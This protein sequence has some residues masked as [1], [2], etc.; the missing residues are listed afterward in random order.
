[1][2][3]IT[4]TSQPQHA[5]KVVLRDFTKPQKNKDMNRWNRPTVFGQAVLVMLMLNAMDC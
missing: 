5:T 3:Y 4:T 1:M 2:C